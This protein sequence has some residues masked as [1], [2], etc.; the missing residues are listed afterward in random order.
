MLHV[1]RTRTWLIVVGLLV[2][3]VCAVLWKTS[4]PKEPTHAGKSLSVWLDE[5]CKANYTDHTDSNVPQ[6]AAVRAIGSNAIPWLIGEFALGAN[7]H[8]G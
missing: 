1:K 4:T 6:V 7:G 8:G 3:L 2:A 5:L